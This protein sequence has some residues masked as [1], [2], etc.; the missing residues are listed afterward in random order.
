MGEHGFKA[1]TINWIKCFLFLRL[2]LPVCV[3]FESN[4]KFNQAQS[5]LKL[6]EVSLY[7]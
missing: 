1:R 4:V 5:S 2:L 6:N 7:L 3:T